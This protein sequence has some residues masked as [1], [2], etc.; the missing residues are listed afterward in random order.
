RR[1]EL[2]RGPPRPLADTLADLRRAECVER[3]ALDGL[4]ADGVAAFVEAAAGHTLEE[5]GLALARALHA[6]T[7]GNPFFMGQVL[8][9]LAGT[10]AVSMRDGQW[11]YDV[12]VEQLGIPDGVREVIG[13]RR[14]RLAPS[15]DAVLQVGSGIGR[16]FDFDVLE[17]VSNKPED[18]LF[19]SLQEATAARVITE[20][21]DAPGCYSFVHAIWR[22]TV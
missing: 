6:E 14:S 18:E 8:R 21:Q 17:R 10:G 16:D 9:H 4:D 15:T 13:R 3:L 22:A 7:E 12:S 1:T 20:V 19:A 2:G 5:S 11:T